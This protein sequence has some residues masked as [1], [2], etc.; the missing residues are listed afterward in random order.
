V[1]KLKDLGAEIYAASLLAVEVDTP[2]EKAYLEQ[3]ARGLGLPAEVTQRIEQM[4]GLG[5]VEGRADF[6]NERSNL[7]WMTVRVQDCARIALGFAGDLQF[8]VGE[9]IRRG[10]SEF[11]AGAKATLAE[12]APGAKSAPAESPAVT[13]SSAQIRQETATAEGFGGAGPAELLFPADPFPHV[14]A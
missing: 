13:D 6:S 10:G 8:P 11:A 2:A 14:T 1:G 12:P 4:I 5:S 7:G 9:T 3:L